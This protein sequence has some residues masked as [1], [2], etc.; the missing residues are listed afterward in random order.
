M[1]ASWTDLI[2]G[3]RHITD[4]QKTHKNPALR[5]TS[6]DDDGAA[7]KSFFVMSILQNSVLFF[8]H[9]LA[10]FESLYFLLQTP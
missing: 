9:N 1:D 7:I 2:S 10:L 3:L 5:R 6:Q 8:H 4:D